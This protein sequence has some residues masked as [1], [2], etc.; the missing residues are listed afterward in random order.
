MLTRTGTKSIYVVSDS[1]ST[2]E[3]VDLD[4]TTAYIDTTMGIAEISFSSMEYFE[5]AESGGAGVHLSGATIKDGTT[6]KP[7]PYE[8][9]SFTYKYLTTTPSGIECEFSLFIENNNDIYEG[10]RLYF[11]LG[12][13]ETTDVISIKGTTEGLNIEDLP[14]LQIGSYL[15]IPI[16]RQFKDKRVTVKVRKNTHDGEKIYDDGRVVY[17]HIFIVEELRLPNRRYESSATLQSNAFDL[18]TGLS[19]RGI[20][21]A[22]LKTDVHTPGDTRIDSY[23]AWGSGQ[24]VSVT[25][26]ELISMGLVQSSQTLHTSGKTTRD[27]PTPIYKL[28][29]PTDSPVLE[30]AMLLEGY[31]QIEIE[32]TSYNASAVNL[33]WW[34]SNSGEKI[35]QGIRSTGI[36]VGPQ[37]SCKAYTCIQSD[38]SRDIVL[39]N[40]GVRAIDGTVNLAS[41]TKLYFNGQLLNGKR[42]SDGTQ[43]YRLP[44]RPGVNTLNILLGVSGGVGGYMNLGQLVTASTEVFVKS[45]RATS[46]AAILAI[47]ET[48]KA[49][50]VQDGVI[51]LNYTPPF[52]A[53]F[54]HRYIL[55]TT[56]LPSS[57]KIKFDLLGASGISPTLAGY[58][59]EFTPGNLA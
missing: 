48:E 32:S 20:C 6:T 47:D 40:I 49:Y 27:M 8:T 16:S 4:E 44:L 35:Y 23:I 41:Y 54:L 36:Y 15:L 24:F 9:N 31:D 58:T 37:T 18:P 11:K 19:E 5:D 59:L 25:P 57:V 13:T 45:R 26:G 39:S 50:A 43:E 33:S 52:G 30:S 51:Y 14:Y 46:I 10:G 34:V 22:C 42:I 21:A 1:F 29:G 53:Q 56:N 28:T 55:P 3:N 17:Q 7:V 38:I 12:F 2:L